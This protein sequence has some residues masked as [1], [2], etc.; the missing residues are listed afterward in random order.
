V[1]RKLT[2]LTTVL[3]MPGGLVLLGALM[4]TILLA[5]TSRGQRVL[6]AF[7]RRVPPRL[8]AQ[9]KRGL[10]LMQAEKLFLPGP[11]QLHST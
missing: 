8:R 2:L 10:Q 3:V 7:K 1:G 6:V 5:R 11:S 9:L 4:L